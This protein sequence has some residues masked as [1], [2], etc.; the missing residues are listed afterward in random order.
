M[1]SQ[2]IVLV[3]FLLIGALIARAQSANAQQTPSL[4]AEADRLIPASRGSNAQSFKIASAILKE[5]RRILVVLPSS[6]SK[7]APDRRYPVTVVVD[8][9]YL[10]APVATVSD[11][12]CRNGQIPES[13]IVGIENTGGADW[14]ASNKKRVYDLTISGV[15]S[16]HFRRL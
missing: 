16:N 1:N 3:A 11:E 4:I 9:E 5:S 13:V 8:G 2:R 12:L 7:S 10:I 14:L 15:G 6:Y